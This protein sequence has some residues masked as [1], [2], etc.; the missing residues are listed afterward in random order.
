MESYNTVKTILIV[1]DSEESTES[2]IQ[3]V[4]STLRSTEL[5]DKDIEPFTLAEF[6]A[7]KIGFML[8]PGYDENS[9]LCNKGTLED[10]CLKIFNEPTVLK[11]VDGY[12]EDFLKS[13]KLKW[14]HKNRLHASFS[15][16]DDYVGMKIGETA[17]AK[18]FDYESP[19]LAPFLNI[20]K[21]IE[22]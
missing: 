20:I 16:T 4:N 22:G 8:F 21:K 18:G 15:F 5:I 9:K 6:N 3:S 11:Q 12:F 17:K 2:A 19:Y 7:K 14:E 13:K 10:L 1:R